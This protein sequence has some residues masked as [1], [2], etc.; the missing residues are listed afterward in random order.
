MV[1]LEC[2]CIRQLNVVQSKSWHVAPPCYAH[3]SGGFKGGGGRAG[4]IWQN[5]PRKT[6]VLSDNACPDSL[7]D[8]YCDVEGGV[9]CQAPAVVYAEGL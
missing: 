9:G 3:S 5:L 1:C 6:V 7:W 2:S 8:T 4:G